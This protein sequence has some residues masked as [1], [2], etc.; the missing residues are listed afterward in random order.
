[1]NYKNE[2]GKFHHRRKLLVK[3][4]IIKSVTHGK[5]FA[6]VYSLF[7]VLSIRSVH[8]SHQEEVF[9]KFILCP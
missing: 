4:R 8:D 5:I 7:Q 1:M 6:G 3:G 9:L 2:K